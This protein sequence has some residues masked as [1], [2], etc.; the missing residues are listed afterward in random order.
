MR[1]RSAVRA[2]SMAAVMATFFKQKV[3]KTVST[4]LLTH[5]RVGGQARQRGEVA[6]AIGHFGQGGAG[7][8]DCLLGKAA[9]AEPFV[10]PARRVVAQ[11]PHYGGI[12]AEAQQ[13]AGHGGHQVSADAATL[14]MV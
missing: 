9:A 10:E 4:N 11:H 1:T 3:T 13:L 6:P 14:C 5:W 12:H 7:K 2:A 8:A